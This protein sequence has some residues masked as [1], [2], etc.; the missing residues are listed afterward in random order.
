MFQKK[1]SQPMRQPTRGV[2]ETVSQNATFSVL[3]ADLVVKGNVTAQADLHL[4]GRIEGD[5]VCASLVQGESSE[6]HGEI[7]SDA[8]RLAGVVRG[9]ITVGDLVVVRSARI[10]GDVH[11]DT[12]TIEQGAVVDGRLGQRAALTAPVQIEG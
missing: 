10:Y 3:A 5:V 2:I 1:P 6:V 9:T 7:R 8:A 11:Y 4:D 12:I